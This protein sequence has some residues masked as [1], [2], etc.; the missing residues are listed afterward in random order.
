MAPLMVAC[1]NGTEIRSVETS[2][3]R[4]QLA[5]R[6]GLSRCLPR[7]VKSELYY[8]GAGALAKVNDEFSFVRNLLETAQNSMRDAI[9]QIDVPPK[10]WT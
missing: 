8:A 1:Q 5:A 9:V 10:K 4:H 7:G 2:P 6:R 3:K